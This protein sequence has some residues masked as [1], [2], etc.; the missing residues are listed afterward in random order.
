MQLNPKVFSSFFPLALA[1]ASKSSFSMGPLIA[2][3]LTLQQTE[4]IVRGDQSWA[5]NCS[6]SSR[7]H[8]RVAEQTLRCLCAGSSMVWNGNGYLIWI[9]SVVFSLLYTL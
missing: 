9:Q 7:T 5:L 3:S 8:T 6:S 4:E 1:T 2:L